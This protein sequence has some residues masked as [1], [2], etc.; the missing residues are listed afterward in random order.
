[1]PVLATPERVSGARAAAWPKRKQVARRLYLLGAQKWLKGLRVLERVPGPAGVLVDGASDPGPASSRRRQCKGQLVKRRR[2]DSEA[3]PPPPEES[4]P[5]QQAPAV[6]AE[7]VSISSSRKGE[8]LWHTIIPDATVWTELVRIAKEAPPMRVPTR[9]RDVVPFAEEMLKFLSMFP[10][11]FGSS[12]I[13]SRPREKVPYTIG[14]V[15][16]KILIAVVPNHC[17]G[18][19]SMTELAHLCPDE[20]GHMEALPRSWTGR[21]IREHLGVQP[22][23]ASCWTCLA[24][25]ISPAHKAGVLEASVRDLERAF[26]RLMRQHDGMESIQRSSVFL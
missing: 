18:G 6:E 1:M 2:L 8:N 17:W 13:A 10:P 4:P 16:R 25:Q 7:S 19:L 23:M 5:P 15:L 20:G 3:V 11:G 22:F 21:D 14:H 26:D 9:S 12:S 24:G